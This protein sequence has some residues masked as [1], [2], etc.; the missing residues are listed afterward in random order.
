MAFLGAAKMALR[1]HLMILLTTAL[2]ARAEG[3]G[4]DEYQVKAAFL[5]NFAKFVEWPAGTFA[6][7]DDPIGICIAGRNPFGS[8]LDDMVRGKKIE[9][10]AVEVRRLA[11]APRPGK[12]QILFIGA[13][14]AKRIPA[15][16][17]AL[18]DGGV[19][20]VGESDSF[21]GLGGIIAF[22]LEGQ[23]VSIQVDLERLERSHLHIRSKLLS[24]ARIVKK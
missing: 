18:K 5:Y 2:Y 20:T 4:F 10:R 21:T 6:K 15:L 8:M 14:E 12:C 1:L 13:S 3:P 22:L 16:L 11:E 24:L 19:L 23:R 17:E 9:E 7:A